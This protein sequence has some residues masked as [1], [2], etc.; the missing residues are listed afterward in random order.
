M[1]IVEGIVELEGVVGWVEVD[2]K[3]M[4]N[5]CVDFNQLVFFKYDWVW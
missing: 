4:I 5:C 3:C 2:D 1:D